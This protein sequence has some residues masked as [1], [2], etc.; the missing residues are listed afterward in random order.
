MT[1]D[2]D[3]SAPGGGPTGATTAGN[4]AYAGFEGVVGRTFASSE[5]GGRSGRAPD[6]APNVVVVLADDLGFADLGCYGSEIPTPNLDAIA[7]GGVR[8]SELPR[9]APVLAD[10]GR[11]LT[12]RNSHAA[13]VG[14]VAQRRSGLPR[15]SGELPP[16]QPS[17]A[18]VFREQRL[19]H[20]DGRQVAP[21]QGQRPQRGRRPQFVAAASAASTST[22]DS[23]RRSRTSTTRTG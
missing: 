17:L 16:N 20:D 21:L 5:P 13:G 10:A 14:L 23:W 6:G 8:Y 1:Y 9:R 19:Q 11:A 2:R 12:G 22:T 15:L 18:E 3:D 7:A 4:G